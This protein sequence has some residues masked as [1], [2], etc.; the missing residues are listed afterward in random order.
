MS[1][2]TAE[3][4]NTGDAAVPHV[5]AVAVP[6][7]TWW[8]IFVRE[9]LDMWVGGKGLTL[10]FIYSVVL[11][12]LAYILA[13]NSELSL[14]APPEM[15]FL[16]LQ[17]A[18][19]VGGFIAAIVGA[20]SISGERERAT[21]EA[22]LLTPGSRFQ[23]VLGKLLAAITPWPAAML[24]TLPFLR[25][26]AEGEPVFEQAL[27]WGFLFGTLLTVGYTG[28]GMLA[29]IWS[30]SNRTSLGVSLLIFIMC[31]LPVQF[32]GNTQT[33]VMG[34]VL[35]AANPMEAVDHVLE[36]LLVNNRT[37]D[38]LTT[39]LWS[40][41]LL[42]LLVLALLLLFAAPR[43][44]LD[45]GIPWPFPAKQRGGAVKAL[46]TILLIGGL[47][48]GTTT[49]TMAAP[50]HNPWLQTDG[51]LVPLPLEIRV[52]TTATVV[53]TGAIIPYQTVV[54]NHGAESSPPLI[55]AMN[56]IN[57]DEEGDVVDP[58]DWSPQ[59]TQYLDELAPGESATQEW[60]LNTIL[61]GDYMV[62]TVV[63]PAPAT[64]ETTSWPLTS[65]GLHVTVNVVVDPNPAGVT[66]SAVGT[67][68]ILLSMIVGINLYRRRQM[69]VE[70]Q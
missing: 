9:L 1:D 15:V 62:Y 50:A 39:Y 70:E 24:I 52:N 54:I 48:Y 63:I 30:A 29:S 44:R 19:L 17:T 57:L 25:V 32:P 2:T 61:G 51:S 49:G 3:I 55:L 67:P 66:P 40:P 14:I 27:L 38:E 41:I 56:I 28:I 13:S 42:P 4:S 59:R 10:L 68:M 22:L 26:L 21:L 6:S 46:G 37:L 11:G 5:E 35:K 53:S 33:G 8:I 7:A 65:T 58:E 18:L 34:R 69:S 36:K 12:L 64:A 31:A 20:D 60:E 43:L 45:A 47:S 23:I 16:I